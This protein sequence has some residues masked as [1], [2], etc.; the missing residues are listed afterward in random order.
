MRAVPVLAVQEG[1]DGKEHLL[2]IGGDPAVLLDKVRHVRDIA[3]IRFAN[4]F[5]PGEDKQDKTRPHTV[6]NGQAFVRI[7]TAFLSCIERGVDQRRP[8]QKRSIPP[9]LANR[10]PC[11][12]PITEITAPMIFLALRKVEAI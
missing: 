6:T 9:K 10:D 11:R 5:G 12:K 7:S 1:V 8:F 2:V 3:K 4:L